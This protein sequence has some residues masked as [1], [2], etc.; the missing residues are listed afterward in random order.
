VGRLGLG[1]PGSSMY[2]AG[3][4]CRH[5]GMLSCFCWFIILSHMLHNML[6]NIC[7]S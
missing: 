2:A 3:T 6:H 4:V 5:N 7:R 1:K